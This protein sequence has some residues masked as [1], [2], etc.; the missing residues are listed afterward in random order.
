MIWLIL[1][2]GILLFFIILYNTLVSKKNKVNDAFSSIDVQ[3]KQRYDLIPN[4]VAAVKS[5][6]QH[7]KSV[8]EDITRLR[9]QAMGGTLSAD[10][11]IDLDNKISKA[12]TNI[13]VAVENYPQLKA[14]QNFL[15]L[16]AS[17]NEVE[18]KISASRRAY[19]AAVLDLNNAIEMFPTNIMASWMQLKRRAW[20]EIPETERKNVNV[21]QLFKS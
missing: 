9:A 10:E 21:D 3:L 7:E 5:Y 19:N 13:L 20:F 4:L 18:E 6:M 15:Q 1:S 16:Q 11:K 12:L 14:N 2:I 8:L 17:L